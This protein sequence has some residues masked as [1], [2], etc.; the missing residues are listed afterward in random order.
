M[1]DN[2]LINLTK[3]HG[4]SVILVKAYL[5]FIW[6]KSLI[7]LQQCIDC[8]VPS[9]INNGSVTED[10]AGKTSYLSTAKVSCDTGFDS[11]TDSIM[12]QADGTWQEASCKIRGEFST[13]LFYL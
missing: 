13:V 4:V 12:C 9:E 10:V 8:G 2:D 3:A 1:T 6:T 11:S 5:Y 7:H